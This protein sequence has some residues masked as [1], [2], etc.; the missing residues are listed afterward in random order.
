MRE[1][2]RRTFLKCKKVAIDGYRL[3]SRVYQTGKL[4]MDLFVGE[5]QREGSNAPDLHIAGYIGHNFVVFETT[6]T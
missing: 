2:G 4:L 1:K 6:R 3:Q 5:Q